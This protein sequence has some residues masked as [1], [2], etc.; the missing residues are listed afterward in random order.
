MKSASK[1]VFCSKQTCMKVIHKHSHGKGAD[2][3]DEEWL[4][5][6]LEVLQ[7]NDTYPPY[8]STAALIL[9]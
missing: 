7:E 2:S 3:C 4:N 5:R 8:S 9:S 1:K 6:V